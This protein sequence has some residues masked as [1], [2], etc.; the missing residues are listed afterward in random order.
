MLTI[1]VLICTLLISTFSFAQVLHIG[2]VLT[3][4]EQSFYSNIID[5]DSIVIYERNVHKGLLLHPPAVRVEFTITNRVNLG[6]G[7][8]YRWSAFSMSV[9]KKTTHPLG[10]ASKGTVV[11]LPTFEFPVAGF[12]NFNPARKLQARVFGGAMG[13]INMIRFDPM[14]KGDPGSDDFPPSVADVL[15]HAGSIP[16]RAYLNQFIGINLSYWRLGLD[17]Y[18]TA[19]LSN[20]MNGPLKI[21]GGEYAFNRKS[22]S[23]RLALTY[24]LFE[25]KGT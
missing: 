2:P 13:V 4:G 18:Q 22:R 3:V 5:L 17:I 11:G 23:L 9:Y 12:Y 1:R 24:K 20:S 7:A 16:K 6:I 21:W 10:P 19:T 25:N 15:N 8:Q 14:Y